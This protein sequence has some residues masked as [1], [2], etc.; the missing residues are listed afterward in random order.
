MPAVNLKAGSPSRE[1]K[2]VFEDLYSQ[3]RSLQSKRVEKKKED[4]EF[5]KQEGECT[6]QPNSQPPKRGSMTQLPF[7]PPSTPPKTEKKEEKNQDA[8]GP[9]G[10]KTPQS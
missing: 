7:K 8:A 6:F 2:T 10:M 3:G 5:E 4:I 9:T 1:E